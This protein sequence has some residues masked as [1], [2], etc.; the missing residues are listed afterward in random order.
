MPFRMLTSLV[1]VMNSFLQGAYIFFLGCNPI[2]WS[3][4]KQ[5]TVARSSIEAEYRLVAEIFIEVVSL[6]NVLHEIGVIGL[7]QPVIYCDNIGAT[8]FSANPV[9]QSDMKHLGVDYHFMREKVQGG[10]LRAALI[11]KDDQ[12]DDALTKPNNLIFR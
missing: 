11:A 9:F 3:S 4:N 5:Q 2:S 10:L 8:H 12:L 6:L 1:T 7:A